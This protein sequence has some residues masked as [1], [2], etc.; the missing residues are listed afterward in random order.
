MPKI[1]QFSREF[2]G[3]KALN[4]RLVGTFRFNS[5]ENLGK[6]KTLSRKKS[7]PSDDFKPSKPVGNFRLFGRLPS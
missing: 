4:L 2:R 1:P 5:R 6:S 7:L 3:L